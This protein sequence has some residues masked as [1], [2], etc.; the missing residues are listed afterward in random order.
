MQAK[1]EQDKFRSK[2][3]HDVLIP[4]GFGMDVQRVIKM[5]GLVLTRRKVNH[6]QFGGR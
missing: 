1:L 6:L 3:G 5:E 2:R 4:K